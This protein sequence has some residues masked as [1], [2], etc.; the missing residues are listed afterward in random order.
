MNKYSLSMIILTIFLLIFYAIFGFF[1][2]DAGVY[3]LTLL[4]FVIILNT[5]F[6]E[7]KLSTIEEQQLSKLN[8]EVK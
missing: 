6:I 8:M 3:I 4:C 5:L 2:F 1:V 7:A